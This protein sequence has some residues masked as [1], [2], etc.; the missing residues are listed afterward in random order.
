MLRSLS[1]SSVGKATSMGTRGGEARA[2]TW[3]CE[4][5]AC[6][7][8]PPPSCHTRDQRRTGDWRKRLCTH[9]CSLRCKDTRNQRRITRDPLFLLLLAQHVLCLGALLLK[10][11][12]KCIWFVPP[13]LPPPS[14][15]CHGFS[16]QP[17]AN[18]CPC[19]Y[20]CCLLQPHYAPQQSN[21]WMP[22]SQTCLCLKPQ[23]LSLQVECPPS[24]CWTRTPV[25][26]TLPTP[27]APPPK[28]TSH[29]STGFWRSLGSLP[30]LERWKK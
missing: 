20:M 16:L 29:Q 14:S 10:D 17:P 30:T 26:G 22:R 21:P 9:T 28:S 5:G 15:R 1:R 18:C 4:A 12:P 6:Q 3:G 7:L 23:G 27:A 2:D 25:S 8:L 24:L 11:V 19:F 13:T